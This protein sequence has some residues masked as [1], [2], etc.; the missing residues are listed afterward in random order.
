MFNLNRKLAKSF[1][2]GLITAG[3]AIALL[4]IIGCTAQ[5]QPESTTPSQSESTTAAQP[6]EETDTPS[7]PTTTAQADSTN[8]GTN[9]DFQNVTVLDNLEHPW[10]IVWLPDGSML[11][12]ERPGR[13]R[14]AREDVLDPTPI[15]GVPDLFAENQGGLLDIALHPRFVENRLVYFTYSHGTND[16]NR[17]RIARATFDGSTLNNWNVIFE[18][19]QPKP[20]G[21]HFGSRLVW[22][23]DG[24]L[25]ASIGDGGNPPIELNG[26]LIRQQAQNIGSHFGKVLRLNDDGSVPSDNPFVA[27]ANAE[28]EVW[29]YGHRNIQGLA[30]NSLT[31]QVWATEHGSRGGDEVNRV[32]AG[33]NYGWPVATHSREYSGGLISPEQSLPG[34]ID[35]KVIWTP[36]IAPSGLAIYTGDRFPEWQGDLFAGG[37]VSQDIR[38]IEIDESGNVVNEESIAI[39]QRVRD[40]R[41]GPDGLLYVLTDEPN[42][43]LIRLTP[44]S[45]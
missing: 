16:A 1:R 5:S 3:S 18:V 37:L 44:I 34:M 38:R 23:P 17:T 28:P 45:E 12:T 25:L 8:D 39:G 36:S 35:P 11:I 24:T 15:A 13:V 21:Q 6:E 19:S 30:F 7:S 27:D 22:L 29:S 33:E 9:P 42:G 2:C 40:V 14:I 32:S 4:S 20:R 31:N 26:E 41:Q 10:G 43:Q